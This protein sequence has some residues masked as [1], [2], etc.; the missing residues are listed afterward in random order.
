MK[1]IQLIQKPQRRGAEIFAAQLSEELARLGHKVILVSIFEGGSVLPFS[2]E[3][4]H[5]NR[6]PK[7]RFWD[8]KAWKHFSKIINDF[9]PDF[10]QANAADTLKFSVFSKSIFKWKT[11]IIYRNANQM[12][13]FI[14]NSLQKKLNQFLLNSVDGVISVSKASQ[15]DLSQTFDIIAYPLQVIP[16]GIEPIQ[17]KNQSAS[18]LTFELPESFFLQI[19]GLVPEK[20]PIEALGIFR[21]VKEFIP[22]ISLVFLGSGLLE[23]S[24]RKKIIEFNLENSVYIISNQ[25]NIFPILRRAKALIMPSKIEGLPGVVLE[26]MYCKVPIIAY[27]V[28]GIP[29]VLKTGETG[30]C[31]PSQ[32]TLSFIQA[33]QEVVAMPQE[34]KQKIL[35]QAHQLVCTHY[36]LPQISLQFEQFYLSL[37]KKN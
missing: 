2:G 5:L 20:D 21:R 35:D 1:I 27:G 7:K 3:F 30:W 12:G 29:E 14:L 25:T 19:G 32:D 36:S 37:L 34:A 9:S 26:A 31:I 4:I 24:L 16:I 10:I 13:D 11:P 33:I 22:K 23:S 17:I 15:E 28:G 8:F 6:N 18:K